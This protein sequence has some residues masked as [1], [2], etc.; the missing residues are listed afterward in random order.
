MADTL[1]PVMHF[2]SL[3]PLLVGGADDRALE[4]LLP[5]E[6]APASAVPS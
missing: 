6:E 3:L 1:S 2:L 5:Q 4:L